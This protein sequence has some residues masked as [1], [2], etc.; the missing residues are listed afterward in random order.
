MTPSPRPEETTLLLDFPVRF[1]SALRTIRLYPAANPQVQR[2]N[3][4]VVKAFAALRGAKPDEAVTIALSGDRLLVCGEQLSDKEQSRPQVRGLVTFLSRM[5]IHSLTFH[6][7]FTLQECTALLQILGTL[8]SEKTMPEPLA[9]LLDKAGITS[10]AVDAM[11]YV[12]IKEGEQVV[13]EEMLGSGLLISDEELANFVL[14][15]ADPGVVPGV[16]LDL[17]Q[18]LIGRLP[19]PE[20]FHQPPEAVTENVIDFLRQLSQETDSHKHDAELKQSGAILAGLD[21]GLLNHLLTNLPQSADTEA[22]LGTALQQLSPQQLNALIAHAVAQNPTVQASEQSP[23]TDDLLRQRLSHLGTERQAEVDQ[24]IAQNL[25]ARQLLL[26]PDTPISKL[27]EHLRQ[28]LL[29]P[30]WSAPVLADAVQ[31]VADPQLQ[32]KGQVDFETFNRLLGNY[33]QTLDQ[34]QQSQLARQAGAQLASM[35]GLALGNILVQRFKGIFGEQLYQE[36]INQIPDQLLDQ[37]VD[38]LSP[39]QIN[40][41]IAAI[42]SDIPLQVGTDKDP[43]FKPSDEAVLKRLVK[44]KRGSEINIAI[45]QNLDARRLLLNPDIP[46]S[47]LPEYQRQ[48][49]MQPGWSAPVLTQAAQQVADPQLQARSQVDFEAF[50]R[51]LGNYEQ[52]LEPSQ[53]SMVARQ[54]GTQMASME[55]LALGNILVQRFKG[56][57]GE[58]LYQQVLTQVSDELLDQ[59]V[60]HL[61][62]K[63]INRMIAAF[64]SNIPM[65]VGKDKDPAF[66]P[67][68]ET[69][70]NRLAKTKRGPEISSMLAQHMDARQLLVNA[71][72]PIDQLPEQLRQRLAQP[73]W[74]APILTRAAQ[75]V[76]DP[77]LQSQSPVDFETFN[78][79]L[80]S[81]EQVLDQN[82][83]SLIARQTGAQMASMEGIA[84]G[85]ILIQR[86]K[87]IFGEQLY[88]QVIDQ[89]SDE[90]LDQTV[91]H[92]TP[93]QLNRMITAFTSE[94]PLQVARD[95]GPAF[96]PLDETVLKRL[97]KTKRGPEI[98]AAVAQHLDARQLLA[99]GDASAKQI[100]E[101]LRQRL[102]RPEWSAPVLT[103]AARQ[104]V[105]TAQAS[106]D[107]TALG[108][109]QQVFD[110]FD[111]L[112]DPEAQ[113]QVFAQAAPFIADF[114]EQELGVLLVRQYKGIFGEQLYRQVIQ[115]LSEEKV[116][117]LME[118]MRTV[119]QTGL[120][121]AN[122]MFSDM[123]VEKAFDRLQ[124]TVR[125]EKVRALVALYHR[126]EEQKATQRQLSLQSAVNRFLNGE[127]LELKNSIVQEGLPDTIKDLL[128]EGQESTA[129]NLLTRLAVALQH[130]DSTMRH[131]AFATLAATSRQLAQMGQWDRV[132]RLLPALRQGLLVPTVT[133]QAANQAMTA[134]SGLVGHYLEREQYLQA[135]G[136]TQILRSLSPH[137]TEAAAATAVVRETAQ[138]TLNGLC[139]PQTLAHLMDLYLHSEQHQ[140]AA[141]RLLS[142]LGPESAK[143]QLQQLI[144]NESR[145]ERRR[146]LALLKQAGNPALAT[147]REQLKDDAPWFVIRNIVRLLGEIGNPALFAEVKPFLTHPDLRVQ[148]EVLTTAVKIGDEQLK[149][150]LLQALSVADDSLKIRVVQQIAS[151][152]DE[153][154][155]RPLTDLLEGVQP[156]N[157]KNQDELQRAI[158]TTL[159]AI[160]SRR[161]NVSLTRVAQSTK[162]LGRSTYSDEVRQA[163]LAALEQIRRW[164]A[165]RVNDDEAEAMKPPPEFEPGADD[166]PS[167]ASIDEQEKAI[168]RL[169]EAGER[170][171]ATKQLMELIIATAKSGDFKTAERLRERLYELNSL[172]LSEIIRSGEIIE[173]EK[174]GAIK[175]E[176]L[177]VWTEL[178]DRLSSREFQTI[179]HELTERRYQPEETI[180][181][182]GE[183]NDTLFFITQGSVKVSHQAGPRELF[184]TTLNRGQIAGEN[185]F[186]PSLW[187]VTLTSLTP[188]RIHVL[189]QSAL[190]TW[191]VEFPRLRQKLHD[192]YQAGNTIRSTLEKKGLERRQDRRYSLARKIQVQPINRVDAPIGRGFRAETADISQGGLAFLI[193]IGNQQNARLLLGRRMLVVLPVGGKMQTLQLKGLV[194]GVQPFQLLDS[195]FSVHFKFER[196]LEPEELQNILG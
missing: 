161:A 77:Q 31:Q 114:D 90:R 78:R 65:Q 80:Q 151:N 58:Q 104:A 93:K 30:E 81:Y 155:V 187:T 116:S 20:G 89:V 57:F 174:M 3:D 196:P 63:Q 71:D 75:Q 112:L 152:H 124:E 48:R 35:E 183:K 149:D 188:T 66:T 29:Q 101:Q 25:D 131:V 98:S 83:Q 185:F 120:A 143:Y 69:V 147:L 49:L 106:G 142:E 53:Q 177:E 136:P 88:A 146:L 113:A 94:V 10:V 23:I 102:M 99:D 109:L 28:R 61:T 173:Q 60:E 168:F 122:S 32:A 56:L 115:Q 7:T 171:Q 33:E 179:Y 82:Q 72:T 14:G 128:L 178:T 118:H 1:Y 180:V 189:S 158:C 45:A 8:L 181:N 19:Q 50:N 59:T 121:P 164:S 150:F 145:F 95:R 195:E 15:K 176:D 108:S 134:I 105:A 16:S 9:H 169:A 62:P 12:A 84:L 110:T 26:N 55:G 119:A 86:F 175:E 96:N 54:A 68:D 70:L 138:A 141:G 123:D 6:P 191:Q 154:F 67:L 103:H 157:G 167:S 186:N 153:R 91:E 39:K 73:E 190:A 27:P 148:Q 111:T 74:S 144:E 51:L 129:D 64:T 130:D 21:P 43:E 162:V 5:E 160:G 24:A 182:Q 4:F 52:T 44:T 165:N 170:D 192:F 133:G 11:R 166:L 156:F 46:I 117:Q 42:T 184:I 2:S 140:E 125:T 163:A 36:V 38:Q 193:R 100:S 13:R 40:R 159:G 139:S 34:Q 194:I 132:A 92:L 107:R 172:A 22:M 87:G 135:C 37:T 17:V 76:T 41:M 126:R 47:E 18:D 127:F 79:L 97:A 85:H 137:G